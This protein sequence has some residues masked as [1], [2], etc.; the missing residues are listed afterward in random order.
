MVEE[1]E[2]ELELRDYLDVLRRRKWIIAGVTALAVAVSMAASLLQDEVY[3]ATAEIL[4]Q[5]RASEEIFDPSEN[6]GVQRDQAAVE[7]EIQVMR[8]QS[9]QKAA[10]EAIGRRPNVSISARG[11][12]SVVA[13]SAD[14]RAP[15]TAAREANAFARA[16]IETRRSQ[17]I[18]DLL[19]A[20]D[21]V[22][23]KIA[24]IDEQL[25]ELE[26]PL[27]D[28]EEQIAAADSP[29]EEAQLRD[30][31]NALRADIAAQRQA[32]Q[33][34]R[35]SY[36][37]Q[38]GQLQ[39]AS[40]L[41]RTGGAQLVSEAEVPI[42]PV[43]P[44]PLRNAILAFVVGLLLGVGLAFLRDYLDESIRTREDV[45]RATGGRLDVLT[46]IPVVSQWKEGDKPMLV[47]ATDP[48]S[49]ASE[50]Y[51]SLRTSIQFLGLDHPIKV[52]QFTSAAA[53][54]GKTTTLANLA[55]TFAQADRR[56]LVVCCDLRKPRIH[57]FYGL[58][59]TVG[60]TSVLLGQVPLHEG[61]QRVPDIPGL[62]LLASGPPPPNP[63]ELLG[64]TRVQ[65]L[66]VRMRDMYDIILVDSPP[67]LPV[68]DAAIL[69]GL[70]DATVVVA[71]ANRTGRRDLHRTVE[72]LAAV[73]AHVVGGVLNG[74]SSGS[75]YYYSYGYTSE[76]ARA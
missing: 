19:A 17:Q 16:F 53:A 31:Q 30:E 36:N 40:N 41:T 45:E 54:E 34:Q 4:L 24:D 39:L 63:A 46:A 21:E 69:A 68:T 33:A 51:R 50:A 8:S 37:A 67:V 64:S 52:L 65:E 29:G 22:E 23:D 26:A 25:S 60:F 48:S 13:I 10:T 61:V 56:V 38:L 15:A 12:T 70:S 71:T 59:N 5:P 62:S 75:A 3:R 66:F 2:R 14:D 1:T 74:V 76:P 47:A 57:E 42:D 55:V 32:L 49:P 11:Q 9:V 35:A 44:K 20:S 43:S 72:E 7:T 18:E 58:R 27:D 6:Q 73:R 28:L